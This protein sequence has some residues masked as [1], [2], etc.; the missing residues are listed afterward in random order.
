MDILWGGDNGT[1]M[2]RTRVSSV[3]KMTFV[4]SLAGSN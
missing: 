4:S 3:K 2:V 1:E